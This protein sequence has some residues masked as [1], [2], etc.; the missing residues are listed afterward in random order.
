[1][2]GNQQHV[3]DIFFRALSHPGRGRGRCMSPLQLLWSG[4]RGTQTQAWSVPAVERPPDAPLV[5]WRAEVDRPRVDFI[6]ALPHELAVLV[7][8]S[9]PSA[10]DVLVAACVSRE[11][12]LVTRDPTI[13]RLFFMRSGWYAPKPV[14][15]QANR[16]DWRSMF[17][18]RLDLERR[19]LDLCTYDTHVRAYTPFSP[20]TMAIHGHSD[21]I[22]CVQ[23]GTV[24]DQR[25]LFSGS[26]DKSIRVW[27]AAS[28]G[29]V[30]L[31]QSHSGSVLCLE[32]DA[33][34]LLS[35]S[36]D[37]TARV[38]SVGSLGTSAAPV[39]KPAV[40]TGHTNHVLDITCDRTWIVTAGQDA[41]LRVWKRS[42]LAPALVYRGHR[43]A[44][45]AC[46]LHDGRVASGSGD[47]RICIWRVDTGDTLRTMV[48]A[49]SGI[50]AVTLHGDVL[51]AG[52]SDGYVRIWSVET[53]ECRCAFP[54]HTQMI[55]ALAYNPNRGVLLTG[56]VDRTAR[57]WDV[58]AA[59]W[60]AGPCAARLILELATHP[61]RLFGVC[62]DARAVATAGEQRKIC[63]T[64]WSDGLSP[65]DAL[66]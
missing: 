11:W 18:A 3:T 27:D 5:R 15:D 55:R 61:D 19:W 32:Y 36:S 33:G 21:R 28:G 20:R 17:A 22:Y 30:A 7:L 6:S 66:T 53:G 12:N 51:L 62:M 58:R 14:L 54:A 35:G 8:A 23:F 47:G 40:L 31:L 49:R 46:S 24:A 10:H 37:G 25:F 2:Q 34:M 48:G 63:L 41:T 50:V 39:P 57:L 4:V 38:W 13:W 26:R 59:C 16:V 43:R 60:D 64:D 29:R 1:M 45:N 44:V 42:D 9:L 65:A 52:S 56:S